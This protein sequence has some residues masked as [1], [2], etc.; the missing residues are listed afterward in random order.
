MLK[1]SQRIMDEMKVLVEKLRSSGYDGRNRSIAEAPRLVGT[2]VTALRQLEVIA[3]QIAVLWLEGDGSE[4]RQLIKDN[5]LTKAAALANIVDATLDE[6]ETF[7]GWSGA[8]RL[9]EQLQISEFDDADYGSNV[10]SLL[11]AV[12]ILRQIAEGSHSN[13]VAASSNVAPQFFIRCVNEIGARPFGAADGSSLFQLASQ[14]AS[15]AVEPMTNSI[16]ATREQ[17]I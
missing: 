2:Q 17:S 11:V 4:S 13:F 10:V 5:V 15:I 12:M 8:L 16:N 14:L 7:I 3:S 6:R 9:I 1:T